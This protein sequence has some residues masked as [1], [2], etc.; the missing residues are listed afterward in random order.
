MRCYR[1]G[2]A[3][4]YEKFYGSHDSFTGW[5]CIMCGEVLD[6]VILEN[7]RSAMI[8]RRER[9]K[10]IRLVSGAEDEILALDESVDS[11][12]QNETL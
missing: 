5:R 7:R 8:M 10:K 2:G 9:K 6:E 11:M 12:T 3:M 1:C 4:T